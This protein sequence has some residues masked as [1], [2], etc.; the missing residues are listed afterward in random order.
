MLFWLQ[1]V[2]I[3]FIVGIIFCFRVEDAERTKDS[4]MEVNDCQSLITVKELTVD[5]A[6]ELLHSTHVSEDNTGHKSVSG[7]WTPS[8]PTNLLD[9]TDVSRASPPNNTSVC[10]TIFTPYNSNLLENSACSSSSPNVQEKTKHIGNKWS[11]IS[12]ATAALTSFEASLGALTRTKKS[13]DR[14]T[15]IAIDCAKFGIAVKV[16]FTLFIY[17]PKIYLSSFK[18]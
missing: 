11:T 16:I 15:R 9:S 4:I 7:T 17:C 10:Q 12:E 2:S 13:I 18:I 6:P 3:N 14:A 1:S 5:S 8:L